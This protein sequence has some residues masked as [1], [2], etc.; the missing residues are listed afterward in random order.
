MFK[1][2]KRLMALLT[3]IGI[4]VPICNA[5]LKLFSGTHFSEKIDDTLFGGV[6]DAKDARI[7]L[8]VSRN[9]R[10]AIKR[11]ETGKN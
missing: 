11:L 5:P 1:H 3:C 6:V 10:N 8:F 2:Y 9:S 7:F 4:S